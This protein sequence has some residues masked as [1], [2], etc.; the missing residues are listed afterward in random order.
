VLLMEVRTP[1]RC[2]VFGLIVLLALSTTATAQGPAVP[3]HS[4]PYWQA[5][6]WNNTSLSGPPALQREEP[7]LDYNWGSGSP[8]PGVNA[9]GFSARWVRYLDLAAGTYRFTTAETLPALLV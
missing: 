1:R 3:Q 8:G 6:Y 5:S 9:D 2:I 4:D 7:S